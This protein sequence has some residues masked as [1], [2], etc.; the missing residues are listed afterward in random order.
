MAR[1]KRQA[2]PP[3]KPASTLPTAEPYELESYGKDNALKNAAD[4]ISAVAEVINAETDEKKPD[5]PIPSLETPVADEPR[6]LKVDED[7]YEFKNNTVP[8]WAKIPEFA[9]DGT[10][11]RFPKGRKIMFLRFRAN[12]TSVPGRGE[13]QAIVWEL[14]PGDL[15]FARSRS[16]GDRNRFADQMTKQC[17][18]AIDGKAV[19]W[20]TGGAINNPEQFWGEIGQGYRNLLQSMISKLNMLDAAETRDF[21]E[22]CVA[23]VIAT[24]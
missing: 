11:F 15:E 14:S 1:T 17:I 19:D 5:G 18:R 10:P 24:G 23:L 16:Q 20:T 22:N 4:A 2:P 13:R 9:P 12:Q 7:K 8:D 21:L 3:G 6:R